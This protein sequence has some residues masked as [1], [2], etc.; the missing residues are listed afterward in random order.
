MVKK[1]YLLRA[2]NYLILLSIKMTQKLKM[3]IN[4]NMK[5]LNNQNNDRLLVIFKQ[6]D[7]P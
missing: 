2:Y 4:I 3:K 7:G 1:K 6:F 5:K